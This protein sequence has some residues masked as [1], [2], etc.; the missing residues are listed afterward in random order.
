MRAA[1]FLDDCDLVVCFCRYRLTRSACAYQFLCVL[2]RLEM[3]AVDGGVM[4]TDRDTHALVELVLNVLKRKSMCMLYQSCCLSYISHNCLQTMT[5]AHR[6]SSSS[7][8]S[9]TRCRSH[10]AMSPQLIGFISAAVCLSLRMSV[11]SFRPLYL[12]VL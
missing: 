8:M 5:S 9:V 11:N 4:R 2:Q 10:P 1:V 12:N 7:S 3:I 6:S